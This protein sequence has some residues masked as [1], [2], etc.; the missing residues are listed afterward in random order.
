MTVI[1]ESTAPWGVCKVTIHL[2]EMSATED[3]ADDDVGGVI[4]LLGTAAHAPR[5]AAIQTVEM[6]RAIFITMI[7]QKVRFNVTDILG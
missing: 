5:A 2:P 3:A 7:L 1:V 4:G 6:L